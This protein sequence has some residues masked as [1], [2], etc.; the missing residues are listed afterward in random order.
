MV[1]AKDYRYFAITRESSSSTGFDKAMENYGWKVIFLKSI[2]ISPKPCPE[3]KRMIIRIIEIN[4]QACVFLS[5]NA[6]DIL[7]SN[8]ESTGSL[9]SLVSKLRSIRTF[10]IGP[11]TKDKLS[12]YGIDSVIL[13]EK[14]DTSGLIECI[15]S[16]KSQMHRI[17]MPRSQ[18]G[19]S[20]IVLSLSRLGISVDQYRLYKTSTNPIIDDEWRRFFYLLTDRNMDA[21]GFT[22]PSSVRALFQIVERELSIEDM[23]YLRHLDGLISIGQKTTAELTKYASGRIIE[24]LEHTLDGIVEASKLI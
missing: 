8:A 12:R 24:A 15:S 17:A 1:S 4:Y 7:M 14:Y 20:R 6:V 23:I 5:G 13:P 19:D 16:Y 3:L 22:S 9:L 10:C 21:I 11:K 18:L 2:V